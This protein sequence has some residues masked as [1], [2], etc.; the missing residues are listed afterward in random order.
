MRHF[1]TGA[2]R[3]DDTGKYDIMEYVSLYAEQRYY[4]HMRKNAEKYGAGNWKL[5]LPVDE[6][7]K[8]LNRHIFQANLWEHEGAVLCK[9][10]HI[11]TPKS[12][13]EYAKNAHY[14]H[15]GESVKCEDHL[16]AARFNIQVIMHGQ[17]RVNVV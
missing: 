4:E 6:G 5:G 14:C 15:C 11:S 1:A 13:K 8:S 2:V 9:N 16:A 7:W 10:N 17:A 12:V 3:D